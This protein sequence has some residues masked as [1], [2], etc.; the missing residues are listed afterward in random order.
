[1]NQSDIQL[2]CGTNL[3]IA[4]AELPCDLSCLSDDRGHDNT[5][6]ISCPVDRWKAVFRACLLYRQAV[7]W[8][9]ILRLEQGV[10]SYDRLTNQVNVQTDCMQHMPRAQLLTTHTQEL[11]VLMTAMQLL[12]RNR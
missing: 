12:I 4:V 1:M 7:A 6:V 2:A 11:V 3:P 8:Q 9:L 10:L 5:F